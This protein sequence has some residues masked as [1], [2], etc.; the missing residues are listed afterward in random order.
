MATKIF[1]PRLGESIIEA[2]VGRWLKQPGDI[3]ARGD[4]IAE[5][6]TAKAMMELESPVKGTL[7]A[8]L[9]KQGD[10][11]HLDEL[12]AV[13][14]N[15]GEEWEE[16]EQPSPVAPESVQHDFVVNEVDEPIRKSSTEIRKLI[17]P[18]AK[19]I[20]KQLGMSAARLNQIEKAGRITG[21]DVKEVVGESIISVD[22]T[23]EYIKIPL[24]Q[25]QSI[26]AHRM[27]QSAFNVPQ[28]SVSVDVNAERLIDEINRRKS[29]GENKVTITTLIT[30]KTAEALSLHP[31]LNSRF[32]E[33]SVFQFKDINIAIA[34]DAPDGLFVPVIHQADRLSVDAIADAIVQ[35]TSRAKNKRLELN[36]TQAG[37][38]TISNLGMK[39]ITSFVP[40]VDPA[41]TAI[42]GVG[43]LREGVGWDQNSILKRTRIFTLTVAADHR[44]VGGAEVSDFLV[45][46]KNLI[47]TI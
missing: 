25:I 40:L 45:T 13:V 44:V 20:A 42:L 14:G 34:V 11:V 37:T 12:M 43:A 18:N 9:P 41:Q 2:V 3:V 15:P 39:G 8:I 29:A 21:K 38:F 46:L 1:L 17:S 16:T 24:N 33:D 36:D 28:F 26:T 22:A 35:L 31:R 4:V 10:T 7:L 6:E 30:W 27:T 32:D 23:L 5:L 19:R 47:E